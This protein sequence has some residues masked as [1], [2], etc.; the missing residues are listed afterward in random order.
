MCRPSKIDSRCVDLR[1]EI[2]LLQLLAQNIDTNYS[3]MRISPRV[4]T[5]V[6]SL[7]C[8]YVCVYVCVCVCVCVCV[9]THNCRL[10]HWNHTTEIP[11]CSQQYSDCFKFC[12]FSK[13]CFVQNLWR[14]MLTSSSSGVLELFS[15][16]NKL[17]C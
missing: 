10:T 6:L 16:R 5:S 8:V 3:C 14:N 1:C 7:S 9:T 11:T 4:C 17:L 15:P 12:R 13:K 2:R